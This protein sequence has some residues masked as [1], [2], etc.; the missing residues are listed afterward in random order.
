[1]KQI[2]DYIKEGLKINSKSKIK[3]HSDYKYFPKT[4]FEF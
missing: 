4:I 1:M 3:E 2:I